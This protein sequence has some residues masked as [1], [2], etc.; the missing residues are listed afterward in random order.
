MYNHNSTP[1]FEHDLGYKKQTFKTNDKRYVLLSP[2]GSLEKKHPC[3]LVLIALLFMK[4]NSITCTFCLIITEHGFICKYIFI[5]IYDRLLV[6]FI[7]PPHCIENLWNRCL[8]INCKNGFWEFLIWLGL[9]RGNNL[10]YFTHWS[11]FQNVSAFHSSAN[12]VAVFPF[13]TFCAYAWVRACVEDRTL[14]VKFGFYKCQYLL[15]NWRAPS[16]GRTQAL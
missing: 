3:K 12:G 10:I 11:Q 16:S 4:I 6:F 14:P 7:F 2:D 15:R 5:W 1:W 9:I 13:S 8:C